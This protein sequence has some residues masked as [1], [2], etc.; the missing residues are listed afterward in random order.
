MHL[1]T[2]VAPPGKDHVTKE[3]P[4]SVELCVF[5]LNTAYSNGNPLRNIPCDV[6]RVETRRQKIGMDVA[7]FGEQARVPNAIGIPIDLNIEE[8]RVVPEMSGCKQEL[9]T[10][11]PGP[12][13]ENQDEG[14]ECV[15]I[16][17]P[18]AAD[19]IQITA[20][21]TQTTKKMRV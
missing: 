1:Q 6:D 10:V 8:R 17:L 5:R 9:P 11:V 19:V 3:S 12:E 21:E 18:E 15:L 14:I 13:V 20:E 4:V 16:S 7:W 2:R